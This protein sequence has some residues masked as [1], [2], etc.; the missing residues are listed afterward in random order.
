MNSFACVAVEGINFNR[1]FYVIRELSIIFSNGDVQHFH[2]RNPEN[3]QLTEEEKITA[4]YSQHN[5]SG[6]GVTDNTT[7]LLPNTSCRDILNGISHCRIYC[8]GEITKNVLRRYLPGTSIIDICEVFGFKYPVKATNP[9]CP[10]THGKGYRYC[11]LFKVNC[12][13]QRIDGLW[14]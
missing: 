3:M 14:L 12:L 10:I 6:F 5:L 2:F 13:R 11:S 1:Y 9:N 8:A 7:C 4:A